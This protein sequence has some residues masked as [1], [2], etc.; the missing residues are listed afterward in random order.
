MVESVSA[1][2]AALSSLIRA[3]STGTS[4]SLAALKNNKQATDAI[5]SQ[6]QEGLD[7]NKGSMKQLAANAPAPASG[8][9]LP[10]GS[11]VDVLV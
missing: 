9:S 7:R 8:S 10:R 3:Q 11:L 1:N 5:I 2:N 6:L 4:S